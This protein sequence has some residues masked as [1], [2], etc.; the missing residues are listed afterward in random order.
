MIIPE[1]VA[2]VVPSG[3]DFD[4]F[5]KSPDNPTPAV[6]PV[7]AGKIMANTKKNLWNS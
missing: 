4:G 5:F 1:I 6:I 7:K 2:K 3:M